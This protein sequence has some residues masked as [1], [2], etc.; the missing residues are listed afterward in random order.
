MATKHTHTLSANGVASNGVKAILKNYRQSP[1][2][3]RLVADMI[4]GKS[5]MH[6]QQALAFTPKKTS[7][8]IAKLLNS[9]IAN[10]RQSGFSAENLFVKSITV[11]KGIVMKRMRPFARGRAGR[12]NKAT[13]IIKLELVSISNMKSA[14]KSSRAG[15]KQPVTGN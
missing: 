7:P 10:A 1:R 14:K 5:V 13:S 8:A 9:A 4:R 2:K 11:D 15:S 6:A 3:V 12:I